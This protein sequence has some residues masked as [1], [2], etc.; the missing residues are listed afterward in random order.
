MEDLAPTSTEVGTQ[1][2]SALTQDQAKEQEKDGAER[3]PSGLWTAVRSL[4]YQVT[5]FLAMVSGLLIAGARPGDLIPVLDPL[6]RNAAYPV[7]PLLTMCAATFMIS[8]PIYAFYAYRFPYGSGTPGSDSAKD[9][10]RELLLTTII[11]ALIG[12]IIGHSTLISTPLHVVITLSH[13]SAAILWANNFYRRG[14]NNRAP[15]IR[16]WL[17]VPALFS[18]GLGFTT[19][20]V[21][22]NVSLSQSLT[23]SVTIVAYLLYF[24]LASVTGSTRIYAG[25]NA[26]FCLSLVALA[27]IG[28]SITPLASHAAQV[29]AVSVV[30][31][32]FIA[33]FESWRATAF[34][35]DAD[36][37]KSNG[38]ARVGEN[39]FYKATSLAMAV[40]IMVLPIMILLLDYFHYLFYLLTV[41]LILSF[42]LFWLT[43]GLSQAFGTQKRWSTLKTI[44]GFL[45]L[46]VIAADGVTQLDFPGWLVDPRFAELFAYPSLSIYVLALFYL[47]ASLMREYNRYKMSKLPLPANETS[48]STARAI[49]LKMSTDPRNAGRLL[50]VSSFFPFVALFLYGFAQGCSANGDCGLL[51]GELSRLRAAEL[52]YLLV[53]TVCVLFDYV[54]RVFDMRSDEDFSV[55]A[56]TAEPSVDSGQANRRA[57]GIRWASVRSAMCRF[58][59]GIPRLTRL[60]TSLLVL[61]IVAASF[62][63]TGN[64]WIRGALVGAP[65]ALTAMLGFTLNDIWDYRKDRMSKPRRAIPAGFVTLAE[66]HAVAALTLAAT[67]LWSTL[68]PVEVLPKG[69]YFAAIIGVVTYNYVVKYAAIAKTLMSAL[70]SVTPI[71]FSMYFVSASPLS[72]ILVALAVLYI[73]GREI[74]MDLLDLEGDRHDGAV[75]LPMVAGVERSGVWAGILINV[76]MAVLCIAAIAAK[77]GWPAAMM[78]ALVIGGQLLC[79]FSW[80]RGSVGARRASIKLQWLPMLVGSIFVLAN[81]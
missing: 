59:V 58:A 48:R 54:E 29:L 55:K 18:I 12:V 80:Q 43:S 67:L 4:G 69:L 23:G 78:A 3:E 27:S 20:Y 37:A 77:P 19:G 74:R 63:L 79:E 10:S 14:R 66:A 65:F 13:A 1:P 70:I 75:T 72:S 56:G 9:H 35:H 7:S 22:G 15:T 34:V 25:L 60:P 5:A 44:A 68:S 17:A 71:A 51:P 24:I 31:A 16:E 57:T 41:V 49:L 6:T 30:L 32:A 73:T 26:T 45:T 11:V 50:G 81:G 64:G 42:Y 8:A 38:T 40:C 28:D 62:G 21:L 76:S 36:L 39:S 46:V 2:V 33:C 53:C 52:L 61:A 47:C